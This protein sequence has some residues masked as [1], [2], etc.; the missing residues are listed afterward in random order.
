MC[1]MHFSDVNSALGL[2]FAAF[3]GRKGRRFGPPLNTP[4]VQDR[5]ELTGRSPRADGHV[6]GER[7][8][9]SLHVLGIDTELVVG[10]FGEVADRVYGCLGLDSC[11]ARPRG[12]Q[13]FSALDDVRHHGSSTV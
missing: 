13:M 12:R 6:Q 1:L 5:A 4:I 10:A 7:R 9:D 11:Y 2:M 8:T 3:R